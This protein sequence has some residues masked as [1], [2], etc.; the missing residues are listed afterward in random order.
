LE[1]KE[2]LLIILQLFEFKEQL[3]IILQTFE[4]KEE[5]IKTNNYTIYTNIK[6]YTKYYKMI[7]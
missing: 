7:I 5:K 6:N 3:L 1:F 2:Q 4:F